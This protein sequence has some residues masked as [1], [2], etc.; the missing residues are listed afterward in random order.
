MGTIN[1]QSITVAEVSLVPKS[2]TAPTAPLLGGDTVIG[3]SGIAS[4]TVNASDGDGDT[5]HY[6][7]DGPG[8]ASTKVLSN[9][10][11]VTV[12]A[13]GKWHYIPGLNSGDL[14]GLVSSIALSTF[15]IYVTDGK[16]GVCV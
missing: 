9:G 10:A 11:I 6:S 15:T 1:G 13:N 16:G 7:V 14:G 3:G 2:N 12:D 5:L 8:G 4:G